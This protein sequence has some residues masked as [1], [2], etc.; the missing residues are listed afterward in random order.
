MQIL[1]LC[2]LVQLHCEPAVCSALTLC[3]LGKATWSRSPVSS[4]QLQLLWQRESGLGLFHLAFHKM[5]AG[6]LT[7]LSGKSKSAQGNCLSLFVDI[8][9]ESNHVAERCTLLFLILSA[10]K[11]HCTFIISYVITDI[12]LERAIPAT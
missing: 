10:R 12:V 11:I 2:L 8:T 3:L 5:G 1:L 6:E 9:V 7:D 4:G